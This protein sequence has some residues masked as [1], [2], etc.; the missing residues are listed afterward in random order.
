MHSY[1]CMLFLGVP[2]MGRN[3]TVKVNCRLIIYGGF[4]I[5][6]NDYIDLENLTQL[7]D[8]FS[9]AV[10]LYIDAVDTKGI[11]L[12]EN[13][14][15]KK[16][17][18]CR[19]IQSTEGA[20][21]KCRKSYENV[22]E[23]CYKWNDTYFSTCHAGLV[24]WSFPIVIENHQ[25]G[26]LV[27][28][29]VLLWKPDKYFYKQLEQYNENLEKIDLLKEKVDE[30]NII[31]A[32]RCKSIA[33][34]ISIFVNYLTKTNMEFFQSK[35]DVYHWRNYMTKQIKERKEKY[36]NTKFD[37]SV[38]IKREKN[39]LQYIRTGNKSKV[40]EILPKIYVDIEI[41]FDYD[42]D[43]I[44]KSSLELITLISRAAIDGGVEN[45]TSLDLCRQ[46]SMKI[47][48]YNDSQE[49][50]DELNKVIFNLLDIVYLFSDSNQHS[51]LKRAKKYINDNYNK[52]ITISDIAK[53][54]YIS[55][56]YLCHLFKDNLNYTVNDYIIRVRIEKSVELMEN[57]ELNIKDIMHEVGF[58]SQSYFNKIFKKILG[59]TPGKYRNKY[60]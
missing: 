28:G 60:L 39:L 46:F 50:F 16:C 33:S 2:G 1:K 26:A 44:K 32:D 49:L 23:E 53:Y 13:R 18:F 30:L 19:Y 21:E 10:G 5:N 11:S 51:I 14:K 57:R 56:Y 45:N 7:L 27:C 20:I 12:L 47:D 38:Y 22:S 3:L 43:G 31:S 4:M 24:L 36:K 52:N 54:L 55:D 59:V 29:Q 17:E 48:K 35:K 6:L 41:L 25:V 9:E 40:E 8:D 15:Y 58:S 37:N 42:L 34:M